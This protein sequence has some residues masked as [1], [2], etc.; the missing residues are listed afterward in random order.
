MCKVVQWS[1]RRWNKAFAE[2]CWSPSEWSIPDAAGWKQCELWMKRWWVGSLVIECA[3]PVTAFEV[4]YSCVVCRDYERTWAAEY[5][6]AWAM[7]VHLSVWSRGEWSLSKVSCNLLFFSLQGQDLFIDPDNATPYHPISRQYI[8]SVQ[9]G[10]VW[11][12]E[13]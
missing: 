13:K 11:T 2:A 10:D 4:E 1:E 5:H 8:W 9:I 12:F 3:R 6:S 7:T